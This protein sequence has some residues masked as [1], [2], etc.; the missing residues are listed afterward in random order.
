MSENETFLSQKGRGCENAPITK[1]RFLFCFHF[2][3]FL[4]F[5]VN[6]YFPLFEAHLTEVLICL[7][8]LQE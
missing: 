4:T 7:K 1:K 3:V 2:T 5:D 6:Y 8:P